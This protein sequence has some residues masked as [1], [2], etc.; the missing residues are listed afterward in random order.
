MRATTAVIATSVLL[1]FALTGCA[2]DDGTST[3][4]GAATAASAADLSGL[5]ESTATACT[6]AENAVLGRAGH[7]LDLE[8]ANQ[9]ITAG[10]TAKSTMISTQ[11]NV[12]E[13]SVRKAEASVGDPDEQ[14]LTAAVSTDILKFRT[15]CQDVEAL[16]ASI[17][18]ATTGGS[19]ASSDP[20]EPVDRSVS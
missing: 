6:L 3:A 20:N 18:K 16:K 1:T 12:L 9:I 14:T 8:S 4:P 7:D 11:A 17:P 10:K 19:G 2:S 5:D 15:V 13:V